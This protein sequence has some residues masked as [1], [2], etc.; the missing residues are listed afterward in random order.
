MDLT[1]PVSLTGAAVFM[2]L[3][4]VTAVGNSL[5]IITILKDP[6]KELKGTA[7]CL[8]LN[9]AVCDLLV[10]IPGEFLFA[11]LHWLP[12][13]RIM[14]V[15]AYTTIYLGF[16]ASF[17]TILGLAV[18]RLIVISSSNS[19]DYLTTTYRAIGILSIWLFALLIAFLPQLGWNSIEEYRLFICD[20]IV[21]PI[22]ILLSACYARIYFLVK[23]NLRGDLSPGAEH[24]ERQCLTVNAQNIEKLKRKERGVAYSVFI[25]VGLFAVCWLPPFVLVN[26]NKFCED[27]I[28]DKYD[29][30]LS[31]IEASTIFLHPL[32]NPIAYSL[33]TVKFRKAL[34]RII[35]NSNSNP[36]QRRAII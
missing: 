19:G 35:F 4:V 31:F 7:N 11:L 33:R 28:S 25:L 17:L 29:D 23:K 16:N 27:C 9:L 6:F 32:V 20:A 10:G 15:A 5:V 1:D 36:S 3:S 13:N 21:I 30:L 18:E 24:A 8:I 26:V 34:R 22:I 14:T 12:D 2:P